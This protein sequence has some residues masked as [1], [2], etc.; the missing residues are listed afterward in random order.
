MG[1]EQDDRGIDRVGG[2]ADSHGRGDA[3]AMEPGSIIAGKYQVERVLGSGGMGV[4]LAAKHLQ[5]GQR[6]AIKFMR[7]E[8]T[9][10]PHAVSRFLRE[11]QAAAALSSEHVTKVLDVGTLESGAPYMVMEFLAGV[12]L[13]AVVRRD[14]PLP[15]RDAVGVVLQACEAIAEAHAMGIVHRDLK[16]ANLFIAR[17]VDGSSLV[18]VL[19]FGI[20]KLTE[21]NDARRREDLTASGSIMGSPGYMSPEQVRNAKAAD[22][23]SDIW[24]LGVILYEIVTGRN[25]F[26]GET[27]GETFA[28]IVSEDPPPIQ[29]LRAD[30][31]G[32]LAEVVRQCLERTIGARIP[33]IDSLASKL[34]PFGPEDARATVER[35]RRITASLRALREGPQATVAA[36]ETMMAPNTGMI[37]PSTGM[38]APNTGT[39]AAAWLR[40]AA[41][42]PSAQ[43]SSWRKWFAI[44]L[45][46]V[47]AVPAIVF[48]VVASRGRN[49]GPAADF[50]AASSTY[51][52]TRQNLAG[53]P[54]GEVGGQTRLAPI[55]NLAQEPPGS[56]RAAG[57][58]PVEVEAS[59]RAD[60]GPAPARTA[61]QPSNPDPHGEGVGAKGGAPKRPNGEERPSVQ[62]S[63]VHSP[64][65]ASHAPP[66]AGAAARGQPAN[67]TPAKKSPYDD[68]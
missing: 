64:S 8:A 51:E 47:I 6:V 7:D 37:A 26:I 25:P 3:G 5:L 27:I 66:D 61:P 18:K 10:D 12:D 52:P 24:S 11:A 35:I 58:L 39:G 2:H 44:A 20:S 41:S 14:G 40:S 56:G 54:G 30:V 22:A 49:A 21:L 46:P 36:P 34:A 19:D 48:A 43:A 53:A 17:R 45:G 9:V 32:G 23:R 67:D 1:G 29:S 28:R 31:P 68:L 57:A 65:R 38:M 13:G 15:V 42:P 63:P 55:G 16:P 50:G 4:V 59:P 60:H 33:T 62:S